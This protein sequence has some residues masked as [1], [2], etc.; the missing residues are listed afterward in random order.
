M[1][2][3]QNTFSSSHFPPAKLCWGVC[4]TFCSCFNWIGFFTLSCNSSRDV[5]APL[6]RTHFASVLCPDSFSIACGTLSFLVC[7][8]VHCICGVWGACVCAYVRVCAWRPEV[9]VFL[10]C[11]SLY[12]VESGFP[13]E[14]RATYL[15]SWPRSPSV[16]TSWTLGLLVAIM[17][18]WFL[19]GC[20][21]P[22][23]QPSLWASILCND[24][25]HLPV[26]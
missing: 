16:S 4:L 3:I 2:E 12:F 18:A 21:A 8:F 25:C 26:L 17:S 6:I 5:S 10:N 11:Y 9:D 24:P 7:A 14:P 13:C 22:K 15:A 23:F 19:C 1:T 20:W